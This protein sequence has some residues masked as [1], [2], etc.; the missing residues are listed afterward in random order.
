VTAPA[1]TPSADQIA[2]DLLRERELLSRQ[3]EA[4]AIEELL[5]VDRCR[6]A[7]VQTRHAEPLPTPLRDAA[8]GLEE[9]PPTPASPPVKIIQRWDREEPEEVPEEAIRWGMVDQRSLRWT[10]LDE[11]PH[12]YS[13]AVPYVRESPDSPWGVRVDML[14]E[15]R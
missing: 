5:L 2:E 3:V 9:P 10:L 8:I 13:N 12:H 7:S 6:S 4:A 15:G 14:G 11:Q 1:T